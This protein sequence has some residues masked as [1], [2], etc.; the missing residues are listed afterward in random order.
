MGTADKDPEAKGW[1][2]GRINSVKITRALIRSLCRRFVATLMRF[3]Q[4]DG[5]DNDNNPFLV[6]G[7]LFRCCFVLGDIF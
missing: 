3:R 4:D 1:A 5:D 2:D 7:M 6:V